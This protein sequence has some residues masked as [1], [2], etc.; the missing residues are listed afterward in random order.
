MI[1]VK[2]V[3]LAIAFAAGWMVE[4]WRSEATI[5]GMEADWSYQVLES[6]QIAKQQQEAMQVVADQHAILSSKLQAE[7]RRRSKAVIKEVIKYVQGPDSGRCDMPAGWVRVH[8]QA[9]SGVP[10]NTGTASA[11]DAGAG[12]VTDADAIAAIASNYDTCHDIRQQLISLQAWA[13]S[14]SGGK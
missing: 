1:W 4:H 5:S 2:A 6:A 12:T 13:R 8:D 7:S 14:V 3:P 11:V 10:E 9:A